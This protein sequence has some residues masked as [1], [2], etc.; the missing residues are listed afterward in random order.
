MESASK[1]LRAILP[2]IKG[3]VTNK[4]ETGF[5]ITFGASYGSPTTIKIVA[6]TR[7]YDLKEGDLL[8][9]YTE[10]LIAK[11]EGNA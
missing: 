11:S 5:W 2:L 6:D 10:V 3:H 7:A 4:T 8:T 1:P 9:L